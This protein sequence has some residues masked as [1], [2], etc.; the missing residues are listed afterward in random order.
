[1]TVVAMIDQEA[2]ARAEQ[3]QTQLTK[4][5]GA[6]GRLEDIACWF[7]GRQA[8]AV[9]NQLIPA[10]ILFAADHGVTAEGISAY[11][12]VVTQEMV[13]NFVANGAAINVLAQQI[14]ASLAVVDVGIA[15]DITALTG[16]IHAKVQHG[17]GNIAREPAM[18]A[19]ACLK[20]QQ[21]GQ[22]QVDAAIA[23]GSTLLIAGEM[24]I[25]NTTASAA[26]I[27]ALLGMDAEQVVG[28]GTGID[29][30]VRQH[31][32]SVVRQALQRIGTLSDGN[33]LMA[34][35]G[36]LE[37][38]AICGLLIRAAERGVPVLLDGFIVTAAALVAERIMPGAKCWWL[39]AHRS[40][41]VGHQRA[42]ESLQL[43]PLLDLG[44]RLGEGSGAALAVPLLQSAI[45]LHANMATFDSAGVSTADH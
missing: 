16:V 38:A 26:L 37:I 9:P 5:Q 14:D 23:Q 11:P 4:P 42:L 15:G 29:A 35:L 6:L 18:S 2:T 10:I 28:Y 41:E 17:S 13:K 1:M 3:R 36:G 22:I 33:A 30:T 40:Q 43:K 20:A 12:S 25:G 44:L 34:Q 32:V 27:C 45:A 8:R 19:E 21:V 31:K 7:A 24:G 39:A